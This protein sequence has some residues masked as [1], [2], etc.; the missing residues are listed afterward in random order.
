MAY[1]NKQK[2]GVKGKESILVLCAHSDDQV[3]GVGGTI[4]KYAQEGKRIIVVIFS[5]GEKS[6]PWLKKKVTAKIRVEESK[7]AEKILGIEKTMFLGIEEGFFERD[8]KKFNVHDKISRL[9][10]IYKPVKIFTHA[11]DD[12]MPDHSALN[13]FVVNLCNEINY[14]GEV[15]SFDVWTPVKIKERNIPALY[16]DINKTFHKKI[17]AL[18][19]FKS[20]WMSMISLL[21][22]VYYRAIKNGLK[23]NCRYAEVF[24]KIR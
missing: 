19:C 7:K 22:S 8:I 4:A 6:H 14:K 20:Q 2:N 21:W 9:V 11:A 18:R 16:V 24:Y 10:K 5:Y 23:A 13:K 15:Y 3:F 1:T 12:P 17:E